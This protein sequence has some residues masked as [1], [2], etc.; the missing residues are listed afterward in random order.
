MTEFRPIGGARRDD[1]LITM[2]EVLA[3]VG[4]SRSTLYTLIKSGQFPARIKR[5][6][7]PAGKTLWRR[8]DVEAW[9]AA[10]GGVLAAVPAPA[11][12]AETVP[13]LLTCP[14][15]GERHIDEG[16]FATRVHHTHACQHCGMVWRPAIVPTVGVRFLPGFRDAS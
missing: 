13:M 5:R 12:A 1:E 2:P 15:C 8:R 11:T 9:I 14:S 4:V 16:E 7:G 3:L 10:D 6:R